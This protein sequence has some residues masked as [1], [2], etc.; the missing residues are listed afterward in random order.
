MKRTYRLID[1]ELREVVRVR[2]EP[3]FPAIHC[4]IPEYTSPIDGRVI[5]SRKQRLEDL[6]RN[7]CRPYEGFEQEQKEADRYRAEQDRK[8]EEKLDGMVEKTYY[9]LR[10][11]MTEPAKDIQPQWILGE[12]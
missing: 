12:D 8:F 11:G 1:G 6:K 7:E 3:K 4:D 9:Q 5:S 10:D 2:Q